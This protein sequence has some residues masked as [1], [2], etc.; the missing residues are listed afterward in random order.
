MVA[1]KGRERTPWKPPVSLSRDYQ[2]AGK[3]R[4]RTPQKPAVSSSSDHR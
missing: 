2:A 1:G 3:G 4:E